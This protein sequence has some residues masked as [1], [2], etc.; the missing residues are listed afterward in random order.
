VTDFKIF[1]ICR[2]DV[3]SDNTLYYSNRE[4]SRQHRQTRS[5]TPDIGASHAMQHKRFQTKV[6]D[7]IRAKFCFVRPHN[8]YNIKCY[9]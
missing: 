5:Q 6:T 1:K 4:S 7:K 9:M 8:V 2:Q 3:L